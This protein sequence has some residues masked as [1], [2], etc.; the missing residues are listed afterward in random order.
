[1]RSESEI[2]DLLGHIARPVE[3]QDNAESAESFTGNMANM[4]IATALAPVTPF[5]KNRMPQQ[6][7]FFNKYA[8]KAP[9]LEEACRQLDIES[10]EELWIGELGPDTTL[11]FWQ[12]SGMS[13]MV[14]KSA[15][16]G[17]CILGDDMGL[18]KTLQALGLIC[19]M[20]NKRKKGNG[21]IGQPKPSL[22]VGPIAVLNVWKRV[23]ENFLYEKYQVH[24]YCAGGK[25]PILSKESLKSLK[26]P[27]YHIFVANFEWLRAKHKGQ[28]KPDLRAVF[29]TVIID[30]A[31][32]MKDENTGKYEV[33]R[34]FLLLTGPPVMNQDVDIAAMLSLFRPD[35]L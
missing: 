22:V 2:K 13:W 29:D 30:K 18:G 6:E 10:I 33:L 5:E 34:N 32:T 20:N 12:P 35:N 24:L 9:T 19:H 26:L 11:K 27:Q 1:M 17:E 3:K 25:T 28:N 21:D 31:H 23:V 15:E 7:E 14:N 4:A 16:I 8:E